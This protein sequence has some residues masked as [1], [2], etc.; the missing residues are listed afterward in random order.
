MAEAFNK[1]AISPYMKDLSI[2]AAFYRWR[3]I[4]VS[5]LMR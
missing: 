5:L 2:S 1:S 3:L 4:E